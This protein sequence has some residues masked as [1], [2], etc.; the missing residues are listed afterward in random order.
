MAPAPCPARVLTVCLLAVGDAF[1]FLP[2]KLPCP[3]QHLPQ[4]AG[5]GEPLFD[6]LFLSFHLL[7]YPWLFSSVEALSLE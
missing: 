7:L 6:P 2:Q 3:A 1:V 5:L 4:T